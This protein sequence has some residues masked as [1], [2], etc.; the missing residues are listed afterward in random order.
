[1]RT[2]LLCAA[3][4]LLP[5]FAWADGEACDSFVATT[6]GTWKNACYQI[7]KDAVEADEYSGEL[8]LST[9]N[10]WGSPEF[11][12]VGIKGVDGTCSATP[13]Y[14]MYGAFRTSGTFYPLGVE[15]IEA[16]PA[17]QSFNFDHPIVK[18]RQTDDADCASTGT[19][20]EI[21]MWWRR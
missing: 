10:A 8:N 16:G 11:Y 14:Q 19:D 5:L 4:S 9:K 17:S 2:L 6:S 3:L 13:E 12:T 18:I 21:V 7:L 15:M 1:M 20:V